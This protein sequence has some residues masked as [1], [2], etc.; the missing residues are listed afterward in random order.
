MAAA[1]ARVGRDP[2]EVSLL[3]V[4]KTVDAARLRIAV[5][6]GLHSFGENR[7]QEAAAKSAALAKLDLRWHLIGHLQRNKVRAALAFACEFQALD[8]LPLARRLNEALQE[9]GRVL[10]V[11]IQVNS[12][13]ESSKYGLPPGEV[14]PFLQ[15]LRGLAS[16][17]VQGLMTLALWSQDETAVRAC[18]RSTR[19]LRD[20]LRDALPDGMML[21]LL[22]MGMSNDFE[23]AIEEGATQ[24]RI[25]QALFGPRPTPDS[26]YW[27]AR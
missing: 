21:E 14:A 1:C 15:A 18:F 5:A 20:R 4:S 10:D 17:R 16:L 22:S 9:Q 11:L 2:A 26:H 13:G 8:N 7:V 25:G 3:P 24:V 19:Q 27:P 12:S 23:W 6:A